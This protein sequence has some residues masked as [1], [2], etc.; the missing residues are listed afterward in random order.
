MP[1][2]QI[3]GSLG[4]EIEEVRLYGSGTGGSS[5][6]EGITSGVPV[7]MGAISTN[8]IPADQGDNNT[9]ARVWSS[10]RGA[11]M[12]AVLGGATTDGGATQGALMLLTQA[13][14]SL[15]PLAVASHINDGAGWRY[16]RGNIEG[17]LLASAARTVTTYSANQTNY[18]ARG[19]IVVLNVTAAS[20]TGGL[21]VILQA[22]DPVSGG[23]VSLNA[24]PTAVIAIDRLAYIFYPGATGGV[25]AQ[26]TGIPLPRTWRVGVV[27]GD[28]SSYTYSLSYSLIL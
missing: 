15:Y 25:A 12:T 27:H 19:V 17:T 5:K 11:L 21:Q 3:L 4:Q 23:A 2:A 20:G 6:V 18:N 28:A 10:R 9:N 26:I 16:Q 8:A 24:T 7:Q 1:R 14:T 13:D 22:I